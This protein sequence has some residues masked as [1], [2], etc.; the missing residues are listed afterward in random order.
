MNGAASSCPPALIELI[1]RQV[2]TALH[3]VQA[4]HRLVEDLRLDSLDMASLLVDIE[5]HH[6]VVV[7][8]ATLAITRTVADLQAAVVAMQQQGLR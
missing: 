4:P 5:L 2:D 8:A 3:P 6:H 1:E 7:D